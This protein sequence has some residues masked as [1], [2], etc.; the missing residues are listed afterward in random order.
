MGAIARPTL[1]WMT[2][3]WVW[4]LNQSK[5]VEIIEKLRV[6]SSSAHPCHHYVDDMLSPAP[7]LAL[8]RDEYT[9]PGWLTAGNEPIF[10]DESE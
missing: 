8:S 2:T 10:G 9:S 1:S 3:A 7:T 6:L 4:R 5:A